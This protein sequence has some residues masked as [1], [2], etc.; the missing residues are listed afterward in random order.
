MRVKILQNF[1]ILFFIAIFFRLF[2]W[3]VIL[4]DKLQ[5][6][7]ENQHFQSFTTLGS[8]GK[9][10]F[11]D[12][13]I[14]ASV[15]P[16]FLMYGLP[17]VMRVEDKNAASTILAKILAKGT[18]EELEIKKELVEKLSEDLYWVSLRKN[19]D[20]EKKERIEELKMKGLGFENSSS[21]FYP[22]GSTSAHL[23]GFVG[24]DNKGDDTGYFG[25]EGF[26]NGDL[27]GIAGRF[28]QEID[29]FGLP[30]I[31]GKLLGSAPKNG[32]DLVLNIDPTVQFVVE[33]TL[34]A[35]VEKYGAAGALAII[36]DPKTGA[37][38]G[39]SSFPNY[40]PL[41]FN[42]FSK[43]FFKNPVVANSY[44]PGSAFKVLVMAAALNEKVVKED[45]KCG[46][47]SGPVSI[48]GFEIRTWNNKYFIDPTMTD[49]I[50]HSDNTGMVFASKKLGLDKMYSY[51][52]NFGFGNLTNIDLQDESAPDIRSKN[53]WREIDLA[54]SSFGQGIAVTPIQMVT[55]VASL[56]NEGKLMEP[57]VVKE[58]R[59]E[60]EIFK[61]K[62][63]LVREVVSKETAKKITEMMVRAVGEGEAK[64]AKPKGFKIAGKTGTAQIPI[65]GHYDPNKT[66]A[67]FV[68]FAPA[69]NPKFVMLVLYN[70]P[71]A[72]IF[73]AETAAPT[74]FEIAKQLF[75]Y[76]KIPPTE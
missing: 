22:E 30:I 65:A 21:R 29:S 18:D 16:T 28:R 35:G 31:I 40:D 27:R 73:G 4:A 37:V 1:L 41:N 13:S 32:K 56:A 47:C 42:K 23:L 52:E 46:E 20:L 72:S 2:F 25:I 60:K 26:Y 3:Q 68:G 44:E 11:S 17:K 75:I 5:S 69:D 76:F 33:K 39:M 54:T 57:Q 70:Q 58:I 66:I 36:M 12:N 7:A 6:K 63:K 38:L 49:V 14:L 71:S 45:T 10:F 55:A 48:G 19:V 62:P 15:K 61:V 24:Q 59:D 43:D 51:I 74:F 9:I 8:R 67:S 34:K 50:I 64:Y 53:N